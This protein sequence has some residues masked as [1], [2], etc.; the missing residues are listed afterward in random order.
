MIERAITLNTGDQIDASALPELNRR[1]NPTADF[2]VTELPKNGLDLDAHMA[3]IER[4]L[5]MQAMDRTNGKRTDAARLLGI[6][7]RSIRYRLSKFGV[8]P[9]GDDK[10]NA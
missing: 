5:V 4:E 3:D 10:P 6:S 7:L 9:T 1:A 8:E 2:D